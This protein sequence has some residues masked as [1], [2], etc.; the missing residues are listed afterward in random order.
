MAVQSS[1]RDFSIFV[2]VSRHCASLRAGLITIAPPFVPQG[3][4][5]LFWRLG[6]VLD[7]RSQRLD[8]SHP[9]RPRRP[10]ER[11][12]GRYSSGGWRL[13]PGCWRCQDKNAGL[14]YPAL[15]LNL[16]PPE[17]RGGRYKGEGAGHS[18]PFLRP[19]ATSLRVKRARSWRSV[20]TGGMTALRDG[21][22]NRPS[23]TF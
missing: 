23:G 17:K 1:L 11:R 3:E 16:R 15:R 8:V 5:A 12:G 22:F 19:F 4:P 9:S 14:K 20:Q 13:E 18:A 2:P 7:V 21:E 6:G 10:P